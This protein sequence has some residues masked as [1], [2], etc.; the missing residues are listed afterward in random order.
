LPSLPLGAGAALA[1]SSP[2]S[3]FFVILS[4]T[5]VLSGYSLNS[6][7]DNKILAVVSFELALPPGQIWS[8]HR[9]P[10]AATGKAGPGQVPVRG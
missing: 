4:S 5:V 10:V 3:V 6:T 8:M 9:F 7:V 1:A 2:A